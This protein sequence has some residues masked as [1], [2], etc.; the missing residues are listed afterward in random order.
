[1]KKI[2]NKKKIINKHHIPSYCECRKWGKIKVFSFSYFNEYLNEMEFPIW[3]MKK[4]KKGI[5]KP[6]IE[7]VGKMTV[8]EYLAMKP[9]V[10]KY[11]WSCILHAGT[12]QAKIKDWEH[13]KH[14]EEFFKTLREAPKKQ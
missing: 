11:T 6:F 2:V 14:I 10:Y 7:Y 9:K 12:S 1:M 8:D 4:R 5:K 13:Y 3:V